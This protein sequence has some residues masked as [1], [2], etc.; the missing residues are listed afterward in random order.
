MLKY[1]SNRGEKA[2]RQNAVI[3]RRPVLTLPVCCVSPAVHLQAAGLQQALLQHLHQDLHVRALPAG[4]PAV[5]AL[6]AAVHRLTQAAP[7]CL[8]ECSERPVATRGQC[9]QVLWTAQDWKTRVPWLWFV[10]WRFG[11]LFFLFFT[12]LQFADAEAYFAPC[13][14]DT[15]GNNCL[16]RDYTAEKIPAFSFSS[17]NFSH[18]FTEKKLRLS[19]FHFKPCVQLHMIL[20][21]TVNKPIF[22]W[23]KLLG[24][25]DPI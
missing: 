12:P 23:Q 7:L 3:V 16:V 2:E 9:G 10:S 25:V 15:T 20:K 18:F 22:S 13:T 5:A 1:K 17:N 6:E 21:T 24:W 8:C 19:I 14:T 4:L 11:F